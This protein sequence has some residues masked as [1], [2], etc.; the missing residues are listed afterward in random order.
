MS[1]SGIDT[2]EVELVGVVA[3]PPAHAPIMHLREQSGERRMLSIYIGVARPAQF[4]L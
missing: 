3:E 4:A 2:V 1:G